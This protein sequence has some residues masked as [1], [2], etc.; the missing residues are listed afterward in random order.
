MDPTTLIMIGAMVLIFVFFII[1]PDRKKKKKQQ[2]LLSSM[3]KGDSIIT[4]G[5]LMG[6]LV[7][8]AADTVTFETGD[9]R[10]RIKITKSAVA[11]VNKQKETAA[12]IQ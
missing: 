6:K 10:V 4:I 11:T 9:D 1:L 5:G 3:E 12:E 8:V 7:D 2:E